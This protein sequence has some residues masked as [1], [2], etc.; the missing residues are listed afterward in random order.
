MRT[1]RAVLT[2]CALLAAVVVTLGGFGAERDLVFHNGSIIPMTSPDV[3]YSAMLVRGTTIERLG[4][5]EEILALAG[6]D[7][8]IVDLAGCAVYPGF[9]DPHTHL[10]GQARL[11]GLSMVEAERLA[12]S[13]G[14]T[15]V[16]DMHIASG[17]LRL[18]SGY[19]DGHGLTI[20]VSM[21]L[22]YNDACGAVHGT[23]YERYPAGSEIAPRLS[24][25]GV[26][27]FS[28]SS[29]C[30]S[31]PLGISFTDDLRPGLSE[32]GR[33]KY[34]QTDPLF[35]ANAMADVFERIDRAGYQ[36][37][38]HAIGDGGVSVTLDAFEILLD[39]GPN[40]RR[41]M[42]LHNWFVSDRSLGRYAD[43]D[44]CASIEVVSPC[45]LRSAENLLLPGFRGTLFRYADLAATGA[46]IA[47]SS[48]WPWVGSPSLAPL[49]KLSILTL[50]RVEAEQ[51]VARLIAMGVA[52]Q[53]NVLT[54]SGDA[55]SLVDRGLSAGGFSLPFDSW[56]RAMT[57]LGVGMVLVTNGAD[58]AYVGTKD[59][60]WH[61][62]VPKVKVAGTAGA[63]DA[64]A[65][66]F[67]GLVTCG[68]SVEDA[69]K[70]ATCNAGSVVSH[71]DTQSGLLTREK[72]AARVKR[73]EPKLKVSKWSLS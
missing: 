17:D 62:T 61:C 19:A 24:I 60:I 45:Y 72:L 32:R 18:L 44:V 13:H 51:L 21:Y 3:S 34:G 25:G 58:G 20:R 55:E 5:D 16:A 41:H 46:H 11:D 33:E 50:N 4:A 49:Y 28:E 66:T 12:L 54:P 10:L 14:L 8:T 57:S 1:S 30:G 67:A 35:E 2:A 59:S 40:E 65:S 37:A 22:L 71:L 6:E 43:L 63:G 47:A 36:I 70:G 68:E 7:A 26:K 29:A 38:V 56:V 69:I 52:D 64:F 15:H 48:D 27:V 23:W 39:G 9:I 42:V 73:Y 53:K 31:Q